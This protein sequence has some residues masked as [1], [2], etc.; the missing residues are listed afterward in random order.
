VTDY[1][2]GR[3]VVKVIDAAS[4]EGFWKSLRYG[5]RRYPAVVVE[6]KET[7]CGTDWA[8]IRRL[9]ER[10]LPAPSPA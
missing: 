8:T 3:V 9:V 6:G 5:V 1:Y 2:W 10:Y 4:V 7:C